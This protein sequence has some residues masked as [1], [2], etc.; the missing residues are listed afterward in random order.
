MTEIE[1]LAEEVSGLYA[2]IERAGCRAVDALRSSDPDLA[3]ALLATFESGDRA[4]DWLTSQPIGFDG[5]SALELLAQGER[6]QVMQVLNH[7]RIGLCT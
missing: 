7:L 6:E 2:D 5:Y 1:R 3:D 4:G